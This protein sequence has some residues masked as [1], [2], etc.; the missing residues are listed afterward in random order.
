MMEQV[1]SQAEIDAL[2]GGIS[3]GDI[4]TEAPPEE[5]QP[6]VQREVAD[7]DFIRFTKGKKE[8]LPALEFIYDRFSKSFRSALSLFMEREV[9]V[10][11]APIQYIEYSEFIK[12]LPLPTNMN[13]VV[14]ENLNG[15]FIVIF[16]AKLI[17]SVL[18]T[19]FGSSTISAPRIE[20]REFTKIEFNVIKK[21]IDLVSVEMEKAWEPVYKIHCKYSRSEINPNYITMV[22]TEETVSLNEFSIEIGDITSWMKI[23]MPYGVLDS[24]KGYL[25][26]TPSREDMEMRERWF[27]SMRQQIMEVPIEARAVL[28]RKKM[29]LQEFAKLG[30]DNVIMV[31]RYVNDAIDIEIHKKTKFR[32]KMGIFKG[33]KAVK[34]EEI[35]Q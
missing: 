11:P 27:A 24:I 1:L 7:F 4:Q 33:S 8:R 2:L 21:L 14:T 15:F 17:F 18:E 23:C 26:S 22:A 9:E 25:I 32:G 31:D 16:D 34:I 19:V 20:G 28:G 12:T 30:I 35:V 3:E 29:S 5:V 10:G 13:I 6:E